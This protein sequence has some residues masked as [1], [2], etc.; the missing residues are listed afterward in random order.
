MIARDA[1]ASGDSARALEILSSLRIER[2]RKLT[3]RSLA[4]RALMLAALLLLGACS[5]TVRLMPTPTLLAIG[6]P[7]LPEAGADAG[8]DTTI[9]VLCAT[10]NKRR[11]RLA[12]MCLE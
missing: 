9:E 11:S 8:K 2:W 3:F 5:S 10:N 6:D 1:L 12:R 4:Q 7:A